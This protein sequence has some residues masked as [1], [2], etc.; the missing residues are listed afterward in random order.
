MLGVYYKFV[1]I[2][3]LGTAV[4]GEKYNIFSL[5]LPINI[6]LGQKQWNL[7]EVEDYPIFKLYCWVA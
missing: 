5:P 4:Y 1:I 6:M 7:F 3:S 2:L